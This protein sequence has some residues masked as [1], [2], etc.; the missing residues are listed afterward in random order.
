MEQ[1]E[2]LKAQVQAKRIYQLLNEVQE[3][4]CQLA[5]ALD[6]DDQVTVRMVLAMRQEPIQ[7][8]KA[9]K[10]CLEEQRDTLP[11]AEGERLAQLL[12]GDAPERED[13]K[14]LAEQVS[15]NQRQL[16]KVLTLDRAINRKLTREKSIYK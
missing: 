2:L 9:A 5:E 7:K 3:L 4:S 8:L 15:A 10:C 16:E 6:R 12:N 14:G 13:E 1:A 11:L